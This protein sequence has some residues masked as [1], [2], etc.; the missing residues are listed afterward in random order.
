MNSSA[1]RPCA[2]AT[3]SVPKT[4]LTLRLRARRSASAIGGVA[5]SRAPHRTDHRRDALLEHRQRLLVEREAGT[6]VEIIVEDEHV[7]IEV[8]PARRH[9]VERVIGDEG[10]VL[11]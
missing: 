11:D 10:A 3:A 6:I 2:P 5:V 1:L 8:G 7:G 4:T 9:Q